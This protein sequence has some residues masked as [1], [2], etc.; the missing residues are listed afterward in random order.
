[1][2]KQAI[3]AVARPYVGLK[4]DYRAIF[5]ATET[6]RVT[7]FNAFVGPFKTERGAQ[8]FATYGSEGEYLGCVADAEAYAALG[9]ELPPCEDLGVI[10]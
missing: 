9:R 3:T 5:W 8:A 1:M 6:P 10:A 2:S 4:G 7:T